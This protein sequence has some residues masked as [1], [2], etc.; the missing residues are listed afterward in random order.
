MNAAHRARSVAGAAAEVGHVLVD[1]HG[2]FRHAAREAQS[3]ELPKHG[4]IQSGSARF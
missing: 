1:I 4:L 3:D 2:V